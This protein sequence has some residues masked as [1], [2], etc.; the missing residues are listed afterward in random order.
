M[1]AGIGQQ[2]NQSAQGHI[3]K[4]KYNQKDDLKKESWESVYQILGIA[5]GGVEATQSHRALS[6]MGIRNMR[7]Y[8]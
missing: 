8:I 7:I 4:V 2:S 3:S 1:K 5:K 6:Q